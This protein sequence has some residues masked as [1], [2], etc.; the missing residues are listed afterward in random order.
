MIEMAPQKAAE[1]RR[2]REAVTV[3]YQKAMHSQGPK[4]DA[5][6]ADLAQALR[7]WLFGL[8]R[9]AAHNGLD[10]PV[11]TIAERDKFYR[12]F[13][14]Q[15]RQSRYG[16]IEFTDAAQW[17]QQIAALSEEYGCEFVEP[18]KQARAA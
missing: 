15:T 11:I 10:Q 2:R 9:E 1:A 7:V 5:K 18:N 3:I 14:S 8:C 12:Q 17:R 16:P 6:P 4:F 13:L